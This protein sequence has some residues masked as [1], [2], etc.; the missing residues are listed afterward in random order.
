MAILLE[1]LFQL[2]VA[3]KGRR[4]GAGR[5]ALQAA[6]RAESAERRIMPVVY[7][8]L[9]DSRGLTDGAFNLIQKHLENKRF[10]VK[11]QYC[12][13]LR[14]PSGRDRGSRSPHRISWSSSHTHTAAGQRRIGIG[15]SGGGGQ[16]QPSLASSTTSS[17]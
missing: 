10:V 16:Y 1:T 11:I 8:P 6:D 5:P 14:N 4:D 12:G 3:D 13:N 2:R 17:E 9:C 7:N 15:N